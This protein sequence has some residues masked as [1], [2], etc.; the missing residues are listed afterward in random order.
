[1]SMN[2][3]SAVSGSQFATMHSTVSVSLIGFFLESLLCGAFIVVFVAGVWTAL[4]KTWPNGRSRRDLILFA[5][6]TAM[7]VL[8]ISHVGIDGH[9]LVASGLLRGADLSSL[10]HEISAL[11]APNQL[12]YLKF[13]I[14]VLQTVVADG[15]MIYRAFMVWSGSWR[16]ISVPLF[17][18]ATSIVFGI[19]VIVLDTL[20]VNPAKLHICQRTYFM[21]TLLTNVLATVLVMRPLLVSRRDVREYRPK[22]SQLRTVRWRVMESI[23]Q[24]AAVFTISSLCFTVTTFVSPLG[25]SFS[26]YFFP[27]IVSMIFTLTVWRICLAP[28]QR[29]PPRKPL[30]INLNG[31]YDPYSG[32]H[33]RSHS[34][35]SLPITGREA[36]C[37]LEDQ[38][39][40]S[41]SGSAAVRPIAIQVSVSMTRTVDGEL[42][43]GSLLSVD[44]DSSKVDLG[45]DGLALVKMDADPHKVVLI[46]AQEDP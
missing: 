39:C 9:I 16:M 12:G 30:E 41:H 37:D 23:L 21:M 31:N 29:E 1:M 5:A 28:G 42:E 3:P 7:F 20:P 26:H 32:G 35:P 45:H 22:G 46:A 13:T 6:S 24:S 8:A 43:R 14:Y 34:C 4:S 15:F 18:Y 11:N 2:S 33:A 17:L 40:C 19:A 38:S 27:P 10:S 25:V 44:R 36:D